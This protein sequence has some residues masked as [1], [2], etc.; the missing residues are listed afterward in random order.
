METEYK[1]PFTMTEPITNLVIEIGE[2]TGKIAAF[3]DSAKMEAFFCM[4]A[5][6]NLDICKS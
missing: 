5:N 2:L 1:P 6:G 4:A 3:S